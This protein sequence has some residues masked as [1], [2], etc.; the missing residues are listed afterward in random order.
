MEGGREIRE[1]RRGRVRSRNLYKG[2][3][4]KDNSGED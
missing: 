4:D 3:I 2:P 1:K